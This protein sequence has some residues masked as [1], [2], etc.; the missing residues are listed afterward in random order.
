MHKFCVDACLFRSLS[1]P[2]LPHFFTLFS[3]FFASYTYKHNHSIDVSCSTRLI[4][5]AFFLSELLCRRSSSVPLLSRCLYQASDRRADLPRRLSVSTRQLG[6][7]PQD[8]PDLESGSPPGHRR[9]SLLAGGG[10]V[11]AHPSAGLTGRNGAP[12]RRVRRRS[13]TAHS[14]GTNHLARPTAQPAGHMPT[15]L[16]SVESNDVLAS[17]PRLPLSAVPTTTTTRDGST[18]TATRNDRD[19][20]DQGQEPPPSGLPADDFQPHSRGEITLLPPTRPT[21]CRRTS[22]LFRLEPLC[23]A[24]RLDA[25][26]HQPCLLQVSREPL[27]DD[28]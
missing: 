18:V 8:F 6:T 4:F 21:P 1:L 13:R 2:S 3:S 11:L 22:L 16:S 5:L 12:F 20:K 23:T 19:T 27:V 25:T 14:A 24:L 17:G 10:P 26:F 9:M 15:R 7:S 28:C